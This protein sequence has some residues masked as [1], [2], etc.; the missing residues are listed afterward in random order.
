ME[1]QTVTTGSNGKGDVVLSVKDLRTY[2]YTRWGITKAVDGVSFDLRKGET[3]GLV[4]ESG[5][6]KSV[7]V[8]SLMRLVP[9]PPGRF[10]SGEIV[11]DGQDI[12]KVSDRE[13]SRIRGRKIAM[14]L[15]DPMTALNPVFNVE[16]QLGE[17]LRIHQKLKG[18]ALWDKAIDALK[19]VRIPAPENRIKDYPHQLSGGMRQRVVGAISISCNPLVLI[20]DEP[21]TS[22]DVT[23]Q[24][25]YLRLLK[26]LQQSAGLAIIFITHDFGI[27]AK[28]CDRVN[29]MYAGKIVEGADVRT[30]FNDPF[31]PYTQA[32]IGSLPKLE[33]DVSRL[34][35]IEGQPPALYNLPQGCS[36]APR[37]PHAMDKCKQEYPPEFMPG[38]EHISR[39]WLLEGKFPVKGQG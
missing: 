18:K 31:H 2:F 35:S 34:Y 10:V 22:L 14:I 12:L 17:P 7:T 37:C 25:Q 36:F 16:N 11:L 32:L 19:R 33:E 29:V 24:A 26:E 3:V 6:G 38:K 5:C 4:G 1:A 13:M 21:T 9:I 28:N 39:C 23:I 20:A 30:V 27:V 15:Q 8:L